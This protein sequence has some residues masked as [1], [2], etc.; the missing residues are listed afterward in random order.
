[1]TSFKPLRPP[2]PPKVTGRVRKARLKKP[3]FP[4]ISEH[5]LKSHHK[6]VLGK[7]WATKDA[8]AFAKIEDKLYRPDKL[9]RP[10]PHRF[11]ERRHPRRK[12]I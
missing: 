1:V 3:H 2:K 6:Q 9:K 4:H 7:D 12:L 11:M 8:E 5:K 10:R